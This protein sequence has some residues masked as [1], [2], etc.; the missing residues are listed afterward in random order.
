MTGRFPTLADAV[1]AHLD[2]RRA[3]GIGGST[4]LKGERA[5]AALCDRHRAMGCHG[6]TLPREL[7]EDWCAL[8]KGETERNR[9]RRVSAARGLALFMVR[10][11][12]EAHVPTDDLCGRVDAYVP[13]VF[14]DAEVSSL[15]AAAESLA[16][17]DPAGVRAQAALV[18]R[19]LYSTGMRSGEA[20]SLG[21]GDV[22]PG[23]RVLTVRHAKNDRER[24]V[25]LCA[26]VADRMER[27][28][29]A[30]E[31]SHPQYCSHDLFWSLPEGRPLT[32]DYVYRFFR[33][34][35]WEAGIHHGGRGKGPRVHDLR[36]T[37]ACHRLRAWAREHADVSSLLPVLATYMGHADT[38]CT[39]YYLRLTAESF[40]GLVD[41]VEGECG[42]V[43]PS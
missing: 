3:A 30:A 8:R 34:A 18:I 21:K 12:L 22:D 17:P 9:Q 43:V 10:S 6:A 2:E 27:F 25:P 19:L 15:L 29:L 31:L 40:P 28:R 39:E 33:K 26:S 5:L 16:G 23:A 36:F 13:Y 38:R 32:T 7:V 41:Q 24:L 4:L 11:G 20:C 14:T 37:F 35:L 1:A 42:W